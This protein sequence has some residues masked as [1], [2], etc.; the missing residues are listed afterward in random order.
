[1]A[2]GRPKS[3]SSSSMLKREYPCLPLP[4]LLDP[5]HL[6]IAFKVASRFRQARTYCGQGQGS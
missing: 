1:M 3:A 6:H 2:L 5:H 4:E